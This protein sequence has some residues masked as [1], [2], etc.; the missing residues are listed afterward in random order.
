MMKILGAKPVDTKPAAA[1]SPP[2]IVTRRHENFLQ[3]ADTSGPKT[4]VIK[5][6]SNVTLSVKKV[7]D[8]TRRC[9][10]TLAVQ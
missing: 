8:K 7:A 9:S 5:K 3:R 6:S 2:T 10:V 4:N 1:R